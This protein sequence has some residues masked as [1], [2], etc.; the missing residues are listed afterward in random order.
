MYWS[1]EKRQRVGQGVGKNSELVILSLILS[2]LLT[3]YM[4]LDKAF[5][6]LVLSL[7]IRKYDIELEI[8]DT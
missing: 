5:I 7:P 4:N 3:L 8:D 2:L 6:V 1:T